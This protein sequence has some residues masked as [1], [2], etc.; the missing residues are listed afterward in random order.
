MALEM[1]GAEG[2]GALIYLPQEGRG[3]GLIEK[4]RAYNLQDKG[5]DTVQANIGPGLPGR[6]ARLRHRPA[7][8]QGPGAHQGPS[9]DE[10]PQEDRRLRVLRLRPGGCRPGADHCACPCGTP[11]LPRHQARQAG[12]L[13]PPCAHAAEVPQASIPGVPM[14]PLTAF[15]PRQHPQ[16]PTESAA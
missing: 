14:T 11:A 15:L 7:N 6:P 2:V 5:M 9:P 12:A 8:P 10:Q 16:G 3:I 13:A 1:I 4:I